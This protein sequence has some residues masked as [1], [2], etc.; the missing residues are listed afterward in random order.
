MVLHVTI[1]C[2]YDHQIYTYLHTYIHKYTHIYIYESIYGSLRFK[3]SLKLLK[4]FHYSYWSSDLG[5]SF[6]YP[7]LYKNILI[8]A[9]GKNMEIITSFFS[10]SCI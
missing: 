1:T 2:I 7:Y 10:F 5:S 8:T 9:T 3:V 6:I 4:I